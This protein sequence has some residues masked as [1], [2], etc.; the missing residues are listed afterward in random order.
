[1]ITLRK[2]ASILVVLMFVTISS[3]CLSVASHQASMKEM[4]REVIISSGNKDAME[5]LRMGAS[6]KAAIRAVPLPGGAGIGI[7]VS[8]W[9]ALGR[10]PV[11]QAVAAVG[12]VGL[13][14]GLSEGYRALTEDDKDDRGGNGNNTSG[15]DTIVIQ[16]DGNNV[17]TGDVEV[18]E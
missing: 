16:G 5:A 2:I 9:K 10:H 14:Y 4:R 6:E 11:R 8:N 13:I 1:M 3:G 18:V 17:N 12:D 7:D 15:G